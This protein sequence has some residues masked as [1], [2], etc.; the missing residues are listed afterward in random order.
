MGRTG[1]EVAGRRTPVLLQIRGIGSKTLVLV[2]GHA[3]EVGR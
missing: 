2:D 1:V 3:V